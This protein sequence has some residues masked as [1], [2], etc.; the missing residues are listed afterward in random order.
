M[1]FYEVSS[2]L[3]L[4]VNQEEHPYAVCQRRRRR[5]RG[6]ASQGGLILTTSWCEGGLMAAGKSLTLRVGGLVLS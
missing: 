2:F 3:C 6:S 1:C 5:P 4:L